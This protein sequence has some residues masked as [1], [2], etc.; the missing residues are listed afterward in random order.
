[1]THIIFIMNSREIAENK[2]SYTMKTNKKK[3][4]VYTNNR[5][6]VNKYPMKCKHNLQKT[7]GNVYKNY[8]ICI[9]Q[10]KIKKNS[11]S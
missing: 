5:R 3:K 11:A 8:S 9:H 7:I 10:K 2:C 1:M 6:N 4:K